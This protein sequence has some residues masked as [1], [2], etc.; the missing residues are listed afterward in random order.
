MHT[1]IHACMHVYIHTHRIHTYT[2][3]GYK[4]NP[5]GQVVRSLGREEEHRLQ[6]VVFACVIHKS[7]NLQDHI[8]MYICMYMYMYMYSLLSAPAG[9]AHSHTK[10]D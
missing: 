9:R 7:P 3:D 4:S 5:S 2:P 10:K 6:I 1:F 8:Y